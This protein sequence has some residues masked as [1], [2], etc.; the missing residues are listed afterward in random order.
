M[1]KTIIGIIIF[2]AIV[3]ALGCVLIYLKQK[4]AV[5]REYKG[6]VV[7]ISNHVM[8]I[9]TI[10]PGMYALLMVE[11]EEGH[12]NTYTTN[13]SSVNHLVIGKQY[14]FVTCDGA[15]VSVKEVE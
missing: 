11:D 4:Y 1:V 3:I 2:V 8:I 5:W 9:D 14:I 10:D 12:V 7:N 15:L 6:T 13:L